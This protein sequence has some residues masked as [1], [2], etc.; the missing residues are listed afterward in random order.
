MSVRWGDVC[1]WG[2]SDIK[3]KIPIS[4]ER[5]RR[6]YFGA[7]NYQT[8]EFILWEYDVAHRATSHKSREIKEFLAS[9]NE[10]KAANEWELTCMLLAPNRPIA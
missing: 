5:N 10:G 6:T 9:V 3:T 1:V 2:Q 7:L 8:K 4:N